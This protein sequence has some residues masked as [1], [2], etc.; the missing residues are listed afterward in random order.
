MIRETSRAQ[1]PQENRFQAK[2]VLLGCGVSF[3]R[4]SP[5]LA[6]E[7]GYFGGGGGGGAEPQWRSR[8]SPRPRRGARPLPS[9]AHLRGDWGSKDRFEEGGGRSNQ[10]AP[11]SS[12]RSAALSLP[13]LS[14]RGLS[15]STSRPQ[16]SAGQPTCKTERHRN[17]PG[18]WTRTPG[19]LYFSNFLLS[20]SLFPGALCVSLRVSLYCTD[21]LFAKPHTLPGHCLAP[22]RA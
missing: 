10:H 22:D 9:P 19:V 1:G 20:I 21:T 5:N 4:L 16:G 6:L 17:Y 3:Q 14:C 18:G 8:G 11:R 12:A 13:A 15:P 7:L 2:A